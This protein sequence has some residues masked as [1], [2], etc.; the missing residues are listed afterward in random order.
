[1]IRGGN[2]RLESISRRTMEDSWVVVSG[3]DNS[4][5]IQ[6]VRLHIGLRDGITRSE[7]APSSSFWDVN[8]QRTRYEILRIRGSIVGLFISTL[9]D[10]SNHWE[11]KKMLSPFKELEQRK[12]NNSIRETNNFRVFYGSAIHQVNHIE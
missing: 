3:T 11:K 7:T 10:K 5:D 8:W 6:S 4:A 12:V 9:E 1:M 2:A